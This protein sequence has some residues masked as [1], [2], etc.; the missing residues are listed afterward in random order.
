[1]GEPWEESLVSLKLSGRSMKT[2]PML[3]LVA[4]GFLGGC[5]SFS[6]SA[7][8]VADRLEQAPSRLGTEAERSQLFS[9]LTPLLAAS[10]EELRTG[11]AL[12]AR[13]VEERHLDA[14]DA[15]FKVDVLLAMVFERPRNQSSPLLPAAMYISTD[16]KP[17]GPLS[18]PVDLNADGSFRLTAVCVGY[19]GPSLEGRVW[20]AALRWFDAER[21]REPRRQL[22]PPGSTEES[23]VESRASAEAAGIKENSRGRPPQP[24]ADH[25]TAVSNREV[26]RWSTALGISLE[27]M[28]EIVAQVQAHHAN[29]HLLIVGVDRINDGSI[30]VRL[31]DTPT[32]P[33]G[34]LLVFRKVG[35]HW[36]EDLVAQGEWI[37]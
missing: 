25:I 1:M 18:I 32:R 11:L 7:V 24:T 14:L 36:E 8:R 23:S 19:T 17:S 27:E 13:R 26:M 15:S 34:V 33:F 30:N 5:R 2:F 9:T 6:G 12:Y 22:R 28:S 29:L 37:A 10:D 20:P 4:A 35:L 21:V 3:L 16:G 31:A